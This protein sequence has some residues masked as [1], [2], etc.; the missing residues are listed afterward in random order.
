MKLRQHGVY[1]PSDYYRELKFKKNN[2]PKARAFM[3]YYDDMDLGEHNSVRFYAKSWGIAVGTAHG[4]ID[5]FKIEIDKY[6][7]TRQ[8]RSDGHYSYAKNESER[9][10]QNQVN[11]KEQTNNDKNDTL[12]DTNEQSE[13]NEMNKGLIAS[14][15]IYVDSKD[16]DNKKSSSK[17]KFVY[18]DKFEIVWQEYNK[19]SGNKPRA[20]NIFESKF[21]EIDFNLIIEAI[22]EYKATKEEWRD[23]KDFDG[24][25]NGMIDI[26]LPKKSWV[27]DKNGKKHIGYFYDS[28]NLFISNNQEKLK[29]ESKNIT[30]FIIE[31]R[32]GYIGD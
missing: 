9:N 15:D 23:L 4:W 29:L 6:Y 32:F 19:K 18:S 1:V 21:K 17:K 24:F 30:E 26:Y 14:K 20:F 13:Q 5:D 31:K 3:E 22:R 27:K 8:L 11:K 12:K 7:T 10:E 16:I 25:L 2:R 28:K